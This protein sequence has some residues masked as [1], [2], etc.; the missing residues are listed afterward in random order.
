MALRVRLFFSA[1]VVC[2]I[3]APRPASAQAHLQ[4]IGGMTSAAEQQPF[5]GAQIGMRL[6]FVEIDIEAGHFQDV[7][8]KGVLSALNELQRQRGLSVQ[9]IASVP[10]EYAV[11]SVRIIPGAGPFRPFISGGYGFARLR[12]RIDVVVEGIS[13]GDVFGLTS[14]SAQTEPMVNLGAGVRIEGGKM[15]VEVGYRYVAIFT[16]FRG[17]NINSNVIT[18][19]NS[20]YG[21]LGVRF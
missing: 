19:V 14:F 18:H 2:A 12:P 16:D 1:A 13:F 5:F 8:S 20:A 3:L 15:H 10:A 4:L 17:F 11:G 9:G 6:S 21:A 7:M